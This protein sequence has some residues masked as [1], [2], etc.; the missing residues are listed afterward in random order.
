[1][2]NIVQGLLKQVEEF[3]KLAEQANDYE[4]TKATAIGS[5]VEAGIEKS[6]AEMVVDG[7][8]EP[9]DAN[10]AANGFA[11]AANLL[12]KVASHI[13]ELEEKIQSYESSFVPEDKIESLQKIASSLNIEDDELAL[14]SNLPS[15]L[16]TKVASNQSQEA[17]NLG[18]ASGTPVEKL[19]PLL[20]FCL[21]AD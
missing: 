9:F 14:L 11:H 19:D 3:T 8:V 4:I 6:A 10:V 12:E 7:S 18:E 21:G 2:S 5:L 13:Q 15:E 17:W 20:S 16:L 1:M